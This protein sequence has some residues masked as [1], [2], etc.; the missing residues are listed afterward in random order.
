MKCLVINGSPRRK[1]TWSMVKE[2]ENTMSNLGE[3]EF[4]E[5][6]LKKEKIPFCRGCFNCILNGEDKCPNS[7]IIQNIARKFEESDCI[8]L[9]SPVYVLGPTGLIKNMLD[10]FAYYYHRPK[11]FNKKALVLVSTQGSGKKEVENYLKKSL[12]NFGVNKVY[13][14]SF[15]FAGKNKLDNKMK[16]KLDK[17]ASDFFK[18]VN[19]K[20]LHSPS[21]YQIRNYSMWRAMTHNNNIQIDNEFW[22]KNNLENNIFAPGIPMNIFKKAY[23][24]IV[25]LFFNKIFS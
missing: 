22:I 14:C 4:Y 11:L 13:S 16:D 6:H 7:D 1:N 21:F 20:K 10:H 25:F 8:I 24:K 9:S 12:F 3:V 18:D 19:S 15:R 5:I 23:A 17:V 2:V